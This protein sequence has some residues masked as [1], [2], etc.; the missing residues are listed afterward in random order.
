MANKKKSLRGER[1]CTKGGVLGSLTPGFGPGAG[2]PHESAARRQTATPSRPLPQRPPLPPQPLESGI[3][4]SSQS[5][6]TREL[7][8]AGNGGA[9][10]AV[11]RG[12][13]LAAGTIWGVVAPAC[14]ASALGRSRPSPSSPKIPAI[15]A[16]VGRNSRPGQRRKEHRVNGNGD[17]EKKTRNR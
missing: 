4:A 5:A 15:A 7:G 2:A 11:K 6:A 12:A 14:S 10:K 16:G 3:G 1:R 8:A 9:G 13:P 17:Q